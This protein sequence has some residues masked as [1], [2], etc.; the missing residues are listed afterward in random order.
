MT[1]NQNKPI[2]VTISDPETGQILEEKFVAND[3]MIVCAGNRYLKSVQIMGRT[4]MLV[5]AVAEPGDQS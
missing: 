2:K 1:T 3:Y 4:H 5:V